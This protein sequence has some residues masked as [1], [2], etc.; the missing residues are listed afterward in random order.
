[1]QVKK[2]EVFDII[3]ED[4]TKDGEG[5]G[6]F[7]GF[8]FFVKDAVIGDRV[9][10]KVM[11]A[12]KNYAYARLL[13]VLKASPD[14]VEPRCP[15]A[16]QCGGCTL[17]HL[18]YEKQLEYKYRKVAGCLERI[19]KV[20][21][22]DTLLE[23]IVGMMT[24]DE[25]KTLDN[26][27]ICPNVC[28]NGPWNYRNKAQFPVGRGKDG[29]IVTGFYAGRSHI[30]IDQPYCYLQAEENEDICNRVKDFM[31]EYH[32]APYDEENHTGVVRHILTRV[33]AVSKEIMVCLVINA[34]AMPYGEELVQA[35]QDVKGICSISYNVNRE[36]TNRI[37]GEKTVTLWGRECI[38]DSI[39]DVRYRIHPKS[40]YQ[41]NPVQTKVLYGKALEY[42]GLSGKE[43]VWDLYCGIGT[44]SLFL[45]Q[46]AKQV[47]GVEIVPEAIG[48]A[49]ENA[50]LNGIE[51]A[52]FYVGKAEE[53]LPREYEKNG[54]RADVIVVDPPRKGCD[55]KA[56]ETMVKMEPERIVYVSCDPAT[57]ARDVKWLSENGYRFVKGCP[58]DMFP[59]GGHVETVVQLVNIGV[60][61][62]YTVRLE[63]DVDEFYKTVGEEKRHFVKPD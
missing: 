40:F 14:R 22:V 36:K 38:E 51:N 43:T 7:E 52:T 11:K 46:Q 29:E 25:A 35:V 54:I 62:D 16:R 4:M 58:V 13:K 37:L 61:P 30:I 26:H 24:E 42:A 18:S 9:Q 15:V 27:L 23:P 34:D 33:G 59:Q 49:R 21:Q 2:N 19:G 31:E 41:V 47:Y 53:V 44:I 20:E 63:V 32:V 10:V 3:I 28:E 55:Q 5:I 39:G 48:N 45:A 50:I 57:L 12:K 8:P 6:K 17:Q 60:K 56:L 1:M